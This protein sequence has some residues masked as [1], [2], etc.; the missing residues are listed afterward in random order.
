MNMPVTTTFSIEGHRI[1]QY[2]GIARGII[3]LRRKSTRQFGG[4]F[5]GLFLQRKYDIV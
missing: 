1:T 2:K 5:G 4:L 3:A